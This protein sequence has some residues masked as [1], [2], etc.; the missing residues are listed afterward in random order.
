MTICRL[1]KQVQFVDLNDIFSCYLSSNILE[2]AKMMFQICSAVAHLHGM[3]IAHR[4]YN[5]KV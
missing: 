3:N 2:V 1:P 5:I 4:G